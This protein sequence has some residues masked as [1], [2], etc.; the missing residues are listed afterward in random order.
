MEFLTVGRQVQG[1][2]PFL[3]IPE[4]VWFGQP[5]YS[6]QPFK[7]TVRCT[8]LCFAFHLATIFGLKFRKLSVANGKVFSNQEKQGP[9]V[10]LQS[11][12]LI[13]AQELN[14]METEILC[15]WQGNFRQERV[16]YLRRSSVCSRKFPAHPRVSFVFH[17]VEPEISGVNGQRLRS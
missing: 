15:K 3:I 17:L 8:G 7:I 16:V 13:M 4:E 9:C 6:I 10:Q 5:K 14:K 2:F 1:R 12:N 11:C